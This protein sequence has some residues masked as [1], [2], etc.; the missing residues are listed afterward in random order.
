MR[1][2]PEQLS[3]VIKLKRNYYLP[4][5]SNVDSRILE[6]YISSIDDEEK[7]EL[8]CPSSSPEFCVGTLCSDEEAS[9]CSGEEKFNTEEKLWSSLLNSFLDRPTRP[10]MLFLSVIFIFLASSA[11][12]VHHLFLKG[13]SG[14]RVAFLG[15]SVQYYNDCP[16]LVE[17]IS[18]S[19]SKQDS[20]L[21]GGSE[22]ATLFQEGNGQQFESCH[23]DPGK[24]TVTDL[25]SHSAKWDFV[26]INDRMK[27]AI[28]D[29]HRSRT[30]Q[31]LTQEYAPLIINSGA[32]PIFLAT[33]ASP[34]ILR[35]TSFSV[36]D[37][38][39]AV[40]EGYAD[41]AA[42]LSPMMDAKHQP[43]I[44]P[45]GNAFAYVFEDKPSMWKKLFH[46]DEYHPSPHGTYLQA[47]VLHCTMFSNPPPLALP[48]NITTL[49]ERARFRE[50]LD[51][52]PIPTFDEAIYL[53]NVAS[54][55]AC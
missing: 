45:V 21:R 54:R 4:I 2:L 46:I 22:S 1:R 27:D 3:A 40:Y 38:T 9:S 36:S 6:K 32:T 25:F 20:V 13:N 5:Y 41:Y 43:R 39:A 29:S 19:I 15:N 42:T 30:K 47:C 51:V 53:F 12:K 18:S 8:E 23:D 16:R 28:L 52:D 14:V 17:T 11:F 50:G 33:H 35:N 24:P 31:A 26:V 37:Y 49:W 34:R 44:A 55:V 48:T 10:V 7:E